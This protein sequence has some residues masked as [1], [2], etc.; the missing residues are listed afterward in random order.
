MLVGNS[1]RLYG[2]KNA[3]VCKQCDRGVIECGD[4]VNLQLSQTQPNQPL[5]SIP[6]YPIN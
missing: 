4:I 3:K 6:T 5:P 2:D 1:A